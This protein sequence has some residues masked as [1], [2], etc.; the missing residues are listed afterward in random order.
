MSGGDTI[1]ALS[2]GLGKAGVAVLRVSGP[3]VVA[4]L[5]QLT[6]APLPDPRVAARRR[7]ADPG[8]GEV[9]DH[10]LVLYFK[11]PA[12]YTGE[13]V[14][15]LHI[16]GGRAT[17]EGMLEILGRMPGLRVAE[18][19]EFT[20]RAF[21]NGKMDLTAVEG[22]A[23]LI[24]AETTLQRRQALRQAAGALAETYEA[25]ADAMTR[26]LAHWE[27]LIDFPDED[28]PE[29]IH[30]RNK[31]EMSRLVGEITQHMDSGRQAE[32]LRDGLS[33]AILGRPNV[34]KSSIL[35]RLAG[36]SAAIVSDRAGTTRDV[37]AVQMDLEGVP[38]TLYDT[39]G[40]RETE[41]EIEAEGTRRARVQARD[42]DIVV[43]VSD[44]PGETDV[45]TS[46]FSNVL[47]VRNKSDCGDATEGEGILLV[48]AVTGAG[49]DHF[50]DRLVGEARALAG[51]TETPVMTRG[52][53]R[54]ALSAALEALTRA[55]DQPDAVLAAEDLRDSVRCIGRITGTVDVE[56]LL[57][58]IFREFCI[59]K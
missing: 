27:A 24:D 26:V 21:S 39:A 35:N 15:E 11:G 53:H 6:G 49:F 50:T 16:H 58:V 18:P 1:F 14:I 41:D 47:S 4:C 10:G 40:L 31:S 43:L 34:G 52:R 3:G 37:V 13:D 5:E 2:S 45:D 51:V 7:F 12:S 17:A 9:I 48:S 25:W 55:V 23:D 30:I 19:G 28:L 36:R 56:D 54:D 38:V 8:S 22:L 32:R 46:Q 33:V 29:E 59:G 57:D 44:G 20:R 42:A